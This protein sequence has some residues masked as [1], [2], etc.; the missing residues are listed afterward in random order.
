MQ[1]K[2][3]ILASILLVSLVIPFCIIFLWFQGQLFFASE[4]AR[5]FINRDHEKKE[6]VWLK[7][8]VKEA[9]ETLQ[10][11]HSKEFEFKGEMYDVIE[12]FF[13]GD[14][15]TYCVYHDKRES[16]IKKKLKSFV[17]EFIRHGHTSDKQK[18][19]TT[20]FFK[21]LYVSAVTNVSFCDVEKRKKN[22]PAGSV[23]MLSGY[24][25]GPPSP[26]PWALS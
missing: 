19:H 12:S 2:R 8:S 16:Q 11:E 24:I 20:H 15:V 4:Q 13:A 17:T 7:F 9:E 18:Q 10:W 6:W 23:M 22:N 26:P 21:S 3:Y 1:T 14:S 5:A 25:K